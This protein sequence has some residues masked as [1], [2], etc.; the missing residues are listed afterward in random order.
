MSPPDVAGSFS[1]PEE[2]LGSFQ[3]ERL[4]NEGESPAVSSQCAVA[5]PEASHTDSRALVLYILGTAVPSRTGV[6]CP[7]ILKVEKTAYDP[8]HLPALATLAAWEKLE[9][10][11]CAWKSLRCSN[12]M[13]CPRSPT[14]TSTRRFWPGT[15]R[16]LARPTSSCRPSVLQA[17]RWASGVQVLYT[18]VADFQG[19]SISR[20]TAS[21]RRN[22]FAKLLRSTSRSLFRIST[23]CLLVR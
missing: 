2:L 11:R 18:N 9:M 8:A 14:T 1:S 15:P 5:A 21:K 12:V 19:S 17:R 7:A 13:R 6:R 4:L 10:V 22:S 23:P 16:E 20:N 3:Y